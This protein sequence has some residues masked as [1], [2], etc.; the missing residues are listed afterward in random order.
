M[1][2]RLNTRVAFSTAIVDFVNAPLQGALSNWHPRKLVF[3]K[4]SSKEPAVHPQNDD[5]SPRIRGALK[6][7][8]YRLLINRKLQFGSAVASGSHMKAA[9]TMK[10]PATVITTLL[11]G[12]FAFSATRYC[13]L[14]LVLEQPKHCSHSERDSRP[15]PCSGSQEFTAE[16]VK[17]REIRPAFTDWLVLIPLFA[18]SSFEFQPAARTDVFA[19]S[20]LPPLAEH[21]FLRF[22]ALLI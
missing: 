3:A 9:L 16:A 11:V 10:R 21:L 18:E 15:N 22:C 7:N 2:P 13:C 5:L 20:L 1:K 4:L 19:A 8:R 12:I 6:L 14:P 17:G